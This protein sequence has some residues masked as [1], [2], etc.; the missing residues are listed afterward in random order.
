M[1]RV[2]LTFR[3]VADGSSSDHDAA[4]TSRTEEPDAERPAACSSVGEGRTVATGDPAVSAD[5]VRQAAVEASSA[6]AADL[7][8][9]LMELVEAAKA[10]P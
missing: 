8:L 5:D 10:R 1:G 6:V 9:A 7:L 3:P 4:V 2:G